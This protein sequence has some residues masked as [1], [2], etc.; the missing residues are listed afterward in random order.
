MNTRLLVLI[1]FQAFCLMYFL[2]S[3]GTFNSLGMVLPSMVAEFGMNWTQA[4]F[5]FTLLGVACGVV[6][7][8]PAVTIRKLGLGRTLLTG[9]VLLFLA[10]GLLYV[11]TGVTT[12]YL[13]ATLLGIAYSFCGTVPAVHVLS[14]TFRRRSL[15]LGLY[16]M[17][18]NL[19]AVA[20]PL[21]WYGSQK[22]GFDWRAY[23]LFFAIASV[24]V[25]GICAVASGRL[26]IAAPEPHSAALDAP[27][28][29]TVRRAIGTAQ[30]WVVVGAYTACLA[31]S[32]TTHGF[33]YQHLME[34][35]VTQGG[36]SQ[37]ISL[38]ALVCAVSSALA[39][40]AGEKISPRALTMFSLGC[41]GVSAVAMALASGPVMLAVWVLAFG[42]GL[43]FSY[44]STAML[45]QQ[46]FGQRASLE[47][48][49]IMMAVSTSAALGTALGGAIKDQT[50]SFAGI[51][52]ALAVLSAV[53]FV[54]VAIVRKPEER[55]RTAAPLV[56]EP[57]Q[58]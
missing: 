54:A 14:S 12:Y 27:V 7:L 24:I 36:A 50:G 26:R 44:V 46:Y 13:G 45:L 53:L 22:A 4:G 52:V 20:G 35:G 47:L 2:L 43:G 57:A 17:I 16:F 19:G 1:V 9:T 30:F 37:L 31:I 29:W 15:A 38:A 39:G 55:R 23:W 49:S 58:G 8:A 42:G 48:Y 18:G 21:L 25:G 40:F 28:E 6:S 33:A 34:H 41:L 10:F 56:A 3:A 51:F 32:T 5:G 11:S